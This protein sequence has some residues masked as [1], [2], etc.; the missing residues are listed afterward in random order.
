MKSRR[1]VISHK[2]TSLSAYCLLRPLTRAQKEG[3]EREKY[4]QESD[5][6]GE[7]GGDYGGMPDI[8]EKN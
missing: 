7:G 5:L 1:M 6:G 3:G 2:L 8:K 4:I